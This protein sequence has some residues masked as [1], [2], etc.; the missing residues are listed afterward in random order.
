MKLS[1][2]R[3]APSKCA[4]YFLQA[5]APIAL[6]ALLPSTVYAQDANNEGG[7]RVLDQVI[8]TGT[9]SQSLAS[10]NKL[11]RE[12]S[13]VMDAIVAED[14]GKFADSNVAESLQ[15]ITGVAIDREGGEGRFVSVRGLGPEFVKVTVNGRT[16][17]AAGSNT[18]IIERRLASRR[19]SFD[20]LQSEMV[21]AL[22]VYKSP[23]ANITTGGIGGVINI[24]TPRPLGLGDVRSVS[25]SGVL[26]TFSDSITPKVSGLISHEFNDDFGVLVSGSLFKRNRRYDLIDSLIFTPIGS[27]TNPNAEVPAIFRP[28]TSDQDTTRINVSSTLQW[29][30]TDNLELVVDGI[31]T[32]LDADEFVPGLPIG[33]N[34]GKATSTNVTEDANGTA[35]TYDT[36]RAFV[37]SDNNNNQSSRKTLVLGG[38]LKHT[39]ELF[40]SS[41]D[42]SYT[43]NQ[44]RDV[45]KRLS[46]DA[47]DRTEFGLSL[48]GVGRFVPNLSF[49]GVGDV[50]N[51]DFF[52]LNFIRQDSYNTTDSEFQ[53]KGDVEY[54]ADFEMGPITV[55]SLQVGGLYQDHEQVVDFDRLHVSGSTFLDGPNGADFSAFVIPFIGP[56]DF[57]GGIDDVGVFPNSFFSIDVLPAF[58]HFI[59][60]RAGDIDP[61]ILANTENASDDFSVEEK[62]LELFALANFENDA[63]GIPFRGNFGLRYVKSKQTSVGNI[64]PIISFDP[65]AETSVRGAIT[66]T[67]IDNNYSKF[68]P[69]FNVAFDV[70]DDVILR[71]GAGRSLTRP[72]IQDLAP[73]M[74]SFNSRTGQVARG[75]PNLSPILSWSGDVSMEWYFDD[76]AIFSAGLFYKDI[77]SFINQITV[78]STFQNPDGTF[79]LGLDGLPQVFDIST[80]Q[81]EAGATLGGFEINFQNQFDSLPAPLDGLGTMINYTYVSSDAEFINP[82]SGAAFDIPGLSQNTVNLGLFYEKGAFSGRINYNYRSDFLE[83]VSGFGADPEF[84]ASYSQVDFSTSYNIRE[85][86]T[87]FAEGLNITD[88]INKKYTS[89]EDR[90]LSVSQTGR[91]FHFGV[92]AK[93]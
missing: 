81:N 45:R 37:R 26:D 39:A 62:N 11:K 68:L 93:F 63:A 58:Q 70:S 41:L 48:D 49:T 92:R 34:P 55:S 74:T 20:E 51:S 90:L 8:V 10:A 9:Y 4:K 50:D 86:I 1:T 52:F 31:F 16:A 14:I 33:L 85:N 28:F 75:N 82:A 24:V 25:V 91:R 72:I 64:V 22:E 88:S 29:R 35:R 80:P 38:N 69:S 54:H 60:D 87:I 7:E 66:P 30:P 17:P 44:T 56:D 53:L 42:V 89:F 6:M 27:G 84:V 19:F 67:A 78:R 79:A 18:A 3:R 43:K 76:D 47:I 71:F 21:S 23:Q 65:S 40:T 59:V 57:L 73:S 13:S 12:A 36:D 5:V 15:R 32:D 2:G 46:A 77:D 61:A 83:L